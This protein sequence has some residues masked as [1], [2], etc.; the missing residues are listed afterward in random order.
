MT[1]TAN[2]AHPLVTLEEMQ[3]GWPDFIQ[4][5]QQLENEKNLLTEENKA[6][7]SLLERAIEH[8]KKSH[9]ELVNLLTTLV[10]KIQINDAGVL[11]SRLVE[12][13][14]QL[15]EVCSALIKGKN[16]ENILQPAILKALEK[17]RTDLKTA[18]QPLVDELIRLDAPL[19][20]GMLRSLVGQPENFFSPAVARANRGFVKGQIP[21]ERVVKELGEESLVYFKDLTTDPRF[22]PHPKVEEINLGFRS[23]FEELISQNSGLSPDKQAALRLLHSRIKQSRALTDQARAQKLAFTKLCFIL[24]LLHYYENQSTESPEVVFAQRLPPLVEQL[25]LGGNQNVLDE[26][27]IKQAEA[28]LQHIVS[29]DHRQAVVN[30]VGKS[31]GLL[32]TLRFVL[33]FRMEKLPPTNQPAL[34]FIKHLISPDLVPTPAA[35]AGLFQLIKPDRQQALVQTIVAYDRLKKSDA[36]NLAKQVAA[37]LGLPEPETGSK[38]VFA[39]ADREQAVWENIKDLIATHSAPADITAAIRNRL[40]AKYDDEEVKLSWLT[41]TGSDTMSLIRVFC[42]LPYL[43]DGQTDPIARAVLQTYVSRLMHEKYAATYAKVIQAL[44]NLFK[45]K[46]DSPALLNFI[47]L[48]RWVDAEAADRISRDVGIPV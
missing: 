9:T 25:V 2:G 22:N 3:T 20:A 41:L 4:R 17:T 23:D 42:L 26:N 34:E 37:L 12:H 32:K 18:I 43:P 13:N 10:S 16:D 48:V 6:L 31:G 36:E 15:A 46:A 5:M 14:N 7:R 40:H 47:S 21:R 35:L 19:D 29:W 38:A 1:Q 8:R 44:R 30:N 11:V 28:L 27:L 39:T 33:A 24:E 45:V